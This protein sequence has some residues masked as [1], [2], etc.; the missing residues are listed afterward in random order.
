MGFCPRGTQRTVARAATGGGQAVQRVP[1]VILR[2]RRQ[3]RR[4]WQSV[5]R[6]RVAHLAEA[7]H[8]HAAG[9]VRVCSR[10]PLL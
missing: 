8:S 9:S 3:L 4:R 7:T 10:E 1:G 2:L 5:Q 6:Q